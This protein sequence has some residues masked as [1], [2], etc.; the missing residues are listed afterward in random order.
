MLGAALAIAA[1][2]ASARAQDDDTPPP[3]VEHKLTKPPKLAKFVEAEYPASEL[4]SGK[5][6]SVV[7]ELALNEKGVVTNVRVVTS[8]GAAFDAAA[9]AAAEKFV[10]EAA[11]I[12]GKPA[13]VKLT[14]KYDFTI[15]S[16]PAG[17]VVNFEGTVRDRFS[18]KPIAGVSVAVIGAGEQKT[19]EK[20]HFQFTDVA[21]GKHTI[22]VSGPGLTTV[23]TEETID[24]GKHVE[25]KYAVEPKGDEDGADLEVVVVAP[26]IQ[27]E[28]VSTTIAADEARKVPGTQGD[29]LKV[30][31]S[32]PGVARASLG[33]GKLVVWGAAPEDTRVYVDGVAIPRLYHSG[34]FR[35]TLSG[36]LVSAIDLSPGG[37]GAEY[38]GGI[39][40]LVT[41]T[42]RDPK[43]D[44]VHGFVGADLLDAS[45]LVETPIGNLSRVAI[46]VRKSY[47]DRTLS[48]FTKRDVG[49]LV[50]I[51]DYF[52]GQ[53]VVRGQVG[54]DESLD[55]ILLTSSDSLTRNV[56]SD[57]PSAV[58]SETSSFRFDR[59]IVRY[60]K[61]NKDG[62]S[63]FVTPSIGRDADG[64]T[65]RFGATEAALSRSTKALGL[66]TGYRGRVAPFAVVSTGIDFE[67][68]SS[69]LE[70]SG[71][72]TSPPREGD[73]YV[74]G[75][76]PPD[77]IN[78]DRWSAMI[79]RVAP[80][81][82]ADLSTLEGRLVVTPG[83]RVEPYVVTGS[84]LTPVKGDT[85]QVG[86]ARED[87]AIE[88]RLSVRF[89]ATKALSFKAAW[90]IYHQAPRA[91]DLSAVFGNPKL[92]ISSA[93]QGLAGATFKI[94]DTLSIEAVGFIS[95][96]KDLAVRSALDTPALAEALVQ[97]GEGRA[98]GG[99]LL[100]RKALAKGFFGWISY[101]LIRSERRDHP[102]APYR[103][104]DQ[105]QT[106]VATAVA[107]YEPGLGFEF[108][109]R[110][111]YAS[112]FPRTPV[113]GS[114]FDS[115]RDLYE[116]YFGR[117]NST[118]LPAF[119]QADVRATKRFSIGRV[120]VEAYLD[121]QNVTNTKNAEEYVYS[122]DYKTR[123]TITGLPILPDLGVRID[124]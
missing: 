40:G 98:F 114:F 90:G 123:S 96:S 58:K 18:K 43:A 4:A 50:P 107:S 78:A 3:P 83:L 124:Y 62:S 103:L 44:G 49:E 29:T 69:E 110:V 16:T 54:P 84:R 27:K 113:T 59:A 14:Y 70:R 9:K 31:Q 47:L 79:A 100:V 42:T 102:D 104:F 41:V 82:S 106:H 122:Y 121:V 34:G 115:R 73:V 19:D 95:K 11:E 57:D 117:Q 111:R 81:A 109:A 64:T 7:L 30:V 10:F 63:F 37:Y 52:D 89:D 22:T 32:M 1:Q 55:T 48:L 105:D 97:E 6:A 15:R 88:P 76:P 119:F 72:V 86:F 118:R 116:P 71:S 80:Y 75:Q 77:R 68:S 85:P 99:Q 67:A 61:Q 21:A 53:I 12:D 46:A 92:G 93:H 65:L 36:D 120:K 101:S 74:F 20:G 87:T 35:S 66:R 5:A 23:T 91:E 94:G 56:A 108:G 39:G 28:V 26:K 112:G 45:G 2:S 60:R 25:V 51:P 8:A 13:P 38:G 24:E 33:S 17:P